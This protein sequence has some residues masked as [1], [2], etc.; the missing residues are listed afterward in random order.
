MSYCHPRFRART[1][2][3]K[4]MHRGR[5]RCRHGEENSGDQ[6]GRRR[7]FWAAARYGH[8]GEAATRPPAAGIRVLRPRIDRAAARLAAGPHGSHPEPTTALR[9]AR[10]LGDAASPRFPGAPVPAELRARVRHLSLDRFRRLVAVARCAAR[11]DRGCRGARHGDRARERD[12]ISIPAL[13]VSMDRETLPDRLWTGTRDLALEPTTPQRR[14][15]RHHPPRAPL[16][17]LRTP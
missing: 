10:K 1:R 16:A 2:T 11:D 17:C 9:S 13:V 14:D 3:H 12:W 15:F 7:I 5:G 4:R 6:L 8:V